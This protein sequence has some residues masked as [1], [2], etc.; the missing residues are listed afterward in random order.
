MQQPFQTD[1][2]KRVFEDLERRAIEDLPHGQTEG[3][4]VT[5]T[6]FVDMRFRYQVHEIRVPVTWELS[7]SEAVERLTEAF[8][9]VYEQTFGTGTAL[10][11]AGVE[12]LT[13]HVVSV[14]PATSAALKRFPNAGADPG[15]ALQGTRSVYWDDGFVD[16][17]VFD[18]RRLATGN[19]IPGPAVIEASNTTI[20]IHPGQ[21]AS[22]DDYLNI[23]LEF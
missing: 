17:P 18:A 8:I 15:N 12:T 9:A 1:R 13:F 6:R 20:L 11:A 5:L 3:E 7:S 2:V 21:R 4:P 22:V 10:R 19:R 16:T 14:V 23:G